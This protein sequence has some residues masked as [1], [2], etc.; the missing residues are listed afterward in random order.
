MECGGGAAGQTGSARLV[1][2][3]ITLGEKDRAGDALL[4]LLRHSA[5][6]SAGCDAQASELRAVSCVA[7][8][9]HPSGQETTSASAEATKN[10]SAIRD[11]A[12]DTTCSV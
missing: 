11:T 2:V 8:S 12:R 9:P 7:S 4:E 5:Q 3:T 6:P 10:V 1:D